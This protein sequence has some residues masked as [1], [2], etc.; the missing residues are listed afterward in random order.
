MRV[1]L[2]NAATTAVDPE[3][4][5]AMKPYFLENY[6]N[7]SSIHTHGRQAKAAVERSRRQIADYLNAAPSEIFFTSGG[8]EAD[9]TALRCSIETN[10][11]RHALTSRIEHHAVLHTL[12]SLEKAG[13]IELTFVDLDEK[14]HVDMSH[15][16]S[17]LK[18]HP[19]SIVSLM[20]AN[21]EI[22]NLNNIEKIGEWC[23]EYGSV[24]HS[25][26]V[27]AVGHYAHDLQKLHVHCIVGAAHKFHGP[28]GTGFLYLKNDH[29]IEPF[30]QGGGQ[31]RNM[32]GGTENVAGIVGLAKSFE[33]AYEK[34]D[35]HKRHIES[36]KKRMI[37]RLKDQIPNVA[38]NGDSAN[39][40]RSLYTVLNVCLP[41][42]EE[43]EML[44]FSLDI[45]KVSA[46][47]GSACSSGSNV[48][49]HVLAALDRDPNRGAI[50]FSFSKFN[51]ADEIDFAVDRLK[52]IVSETQMA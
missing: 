49:S 28:K 19:N 25:D 51:T 30:I 52:E 50:R 34:M 3:V 20:H 21:N 26:T 16:Q 9:N 6:G 37:E 42:S 39:L 13:K 32:R 29:I 38:F 48:G 47:G 15:L 4:F 17:W 5:E 43:N 33:L 27:Q 24:F 2:D 7:P 12:E 11:I 40:E 1:Y 45:N 18:D 36:L 23:Q 31:E 22:G 10:N 14:G 44:L 8:T 35:E 41:P 46:S